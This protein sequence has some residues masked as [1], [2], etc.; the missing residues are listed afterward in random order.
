MVSFLYKVYFTLK[1]FFFGFLKN[2]EKYFTIHLH[3]VTIHY[4]SFFIDDDMF[5]FWLKLEIMKKLLNYIK[6]S[7]LFTV[8]THI[9]VIIFL[10]IFN[11]FD[12]EYFLYLT[13]LTISFLLVPS[14]L[15]LLIYDSSKTVF[16]NLLKPAVINFFIL[17]FFTFIYLMFVENYKTI[18]FYNS[19]IITT[20][21]L[22]STV[23]V[24]FTLFQ[25]IGTNSNQVNNYNLKDLNYSFFKLFLIPFSGSIIYSLIITIDKFDNHD[26]ILIFYK[27]LPIGFI[28]SLISMH[29]FNYI[30]SKYKQSKRVYYIVSYYVISISLLVFWI[31][32]SY[33]NFRIVKDGLGAMIDRAF[34]LPSIGLYTPFFLFVLILSH[35]YFLS[36]VNKLEKNILTQQSIESQLNYQQLKN[37][38][39]PHFLFNN[40]NVLTSLIEENP[41]KAVRFSENLSHIYRY[42]LEQEKQDVVLVK[43]EVSFTKSYLELLKDRFEIGLNFSIL[44]DEKVNEKYIVSTILQQVL[45]N[46]VKH[47]EINETKIVD[48]KITSKENYLIIK[49]NKN[50]KIKTVENSNKGI[51][52]I[53]KRIAFFTDEKVVIEDSATDFII[54]L[55]ILETV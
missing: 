20:A 50:P 55:P 10:I 12:Y 33:N 6:K 16:Q 15:S 5:H 17:Y 23:S 4:I 44:V 27:F 31:I 36:L 46:V 18:S 1:S 14:F 8:I 51:E 22:S 24:F 39:S 42:F 3:K 29:F 49:N 53:K 37:Q 30:F 40:I 47:N 7:I 54:K 25:K 28:F 41:K 21:F 34:L 48:V 35:L 2:I 38:L 26:I 11:G 9:I 19:K 43:D 13:P 52:N 32:I 45:E